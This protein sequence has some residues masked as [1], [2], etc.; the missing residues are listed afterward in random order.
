MTLNSDLLSPG[1]LEV[2]GGR[3]CLRFR[4]TL[5]HPVERVWRA[6]T[7]SGEL[8]RWFPADLE[9]AREPGATIRIVSWSSRFPPTVGTITDCSSPRR[10][11]FT[12]GGEVLLW[13]LCPT[14]AGCDLAFT[15]VLDDQSMAIGAAEIAAAWHA[16]LDVLDY[17]L[18]DQA[19]PYTVDERFHQVSA[20]YRDRFTLRAAAP[21]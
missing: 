17:V 9:G 21:K 12:W 7:E 11:E 15:N 20:A 19:A 13:E 10:F 6:V 4:R 18:A 8:A 3:H 14:V 1:V 2:S 5:T 16:C